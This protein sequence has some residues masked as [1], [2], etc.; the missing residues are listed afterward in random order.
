MAGKRNRTKKASLFN[1]AAST[2]QAAQS[3]TVLPSQSGF[4]AT[5]DFFAVVTPSAD[6][7]RLRIFDTKR[8]DAPVVATLS[9]SSNLETPGSPKNYTCLSCGIV[10]GEPADVR[11][12]TDG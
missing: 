9:P 7:H 3:E 10:R 1:S 8:N 11:Y 5:G 2:A 4:D 6:E 12:F